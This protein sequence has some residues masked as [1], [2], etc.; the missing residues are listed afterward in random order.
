MINS[1]DHNIYWPL[2][3]RRGRQ[4]TVTTSIADNASSASSL[5]LYGGDAA[6]I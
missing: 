3:T 2:W 5:L 6:G 1:R 4:G